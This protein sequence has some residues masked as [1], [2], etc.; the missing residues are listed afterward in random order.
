MNKIKAISALTV[1]LMSAAVTSTPAS[2]QVNTQVFPA[3]MCQPINSTSATNLVFFSSD[4]INSNGGGNV[5]CPIPSNPLFS[6]FR[7]VVFRV[8]VSGSQ[9]LRPSCTLRSFRI[10]P[11]TFLG[12]KV[13]DE[14]AILNTAGN[15]LVAVAD[16]QDYYIATCALQSGTK[17]T[18]Y[19]LQGI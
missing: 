3:S 8:G 14:P 2:A 4:S 11:F 9:G 13:K 10:D 7:R 18:N 1:T 15:T 17:I 19:S 12:T 6:S 16:A 5:I